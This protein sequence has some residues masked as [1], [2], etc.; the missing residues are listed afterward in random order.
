MYYCY[1]CPCSILFPKF[2]CSMPLDIFN[3]FKKNISK[4]FTIYK[5]LNNTIYGKNINWVRESVYYVNFAGNRKKLTFV[6]TLFSYYSMERVS[7]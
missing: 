3:I 5:K 7:E 1:D 2:V 4:L 6:Q